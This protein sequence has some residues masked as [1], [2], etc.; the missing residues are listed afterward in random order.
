MKRPMLYWVILFML[1]EALYRILPIGIIIVIAAGMV[2]GI[3][4]IPAALV[5]KYKKVLFVGI[6]FFLFG[7][8]RLGDIR[9]QLSLCQMEEGVQVMVQGTVTG[10]N[11]S[12]ENQY[13]ILKAEK[14]NGEIIHIGIRL[15]LKTEDTIVL[16]SR[17]KGTG[18]TKAFGNATNPGEYDEQSYQYG[19]GVFLFLQDVEIIEK[20]EPVVPLRESLYQ[21]RQNVSKVYITLFGE[22]NGSLAAAM[23]LGNKESLDRD[24]KQ[25]YQR[26]GIA[27]LIAI[28][29][30]H[31]AM[32][33]G[34]LYHFLRKLLGSYP[35]SAGIGIFF[36]ILYGVMTGLSGA[37][38]RAVIMLITSIGAEVSG[39]RY[40]SITAVSLALF[41]M[42]VINP[43]QITQVGFLLS[44]GAILGIVL[45]YPVWKQLFPKMPQCLDG[46][47][48]SISVQLMI[49][50]VMLFYFYEV[51]VYGILLNV[52]VVPLMGILL[53]LLLLCGI[54]GSLYLKAGVL[55]AKPAQMIFVHYEQLCNVS[56][57]FPMHT[58]CT[59]RPSVLWLL[60]YYGILSLILAAGYQ[61]KYKLMSMS[62]ILY[63]G[64]FFLFFLPGNLKICMFDVGQGDGIYIRTPDGKHILMDGGSSSK[65]KVG[66]YVL[67]NG[68]KFYGGS[69]L[70]YVFISH[71]DSDHYSGILELFDEET[72]HIKHLVLPAVSNPDET[73]IQIEEKALE[74]GCDIHYMKRGDQLQVGKVTFYCLNP[75]KKAYEDKN[76]GSLVFLA[77]YGDFDILLTGDMDETVE[78]EI[79]DKITA[80]VEVL[81]VAHHGSASSSSE[82]FLRKLQPVTACVSV[83]EKNRY[84]HPADEVM[85]RLGQFCKKIYLTKDSGA[86][87]IDTNGKRYQITTFLTE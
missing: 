54:A 23:V 74:K 15:S 22:R 77:T 25:L 44:F 60:C 69:N 57:N 52:I 83:G 46:L 40:D 13:Y 1:G 79:A 3:R 66:T 35:V 87:T 5:K 65:Q 49:L 28:S 56:E 10:I 12:G 61:K 48:V 70:D 71:I 53:A 84:G 59:G 9:K 51:P 50:P 26:N 20:K 72:I 47:M 62:S 76:Q 14:V 33:G 63:I 29:G 42:L 32:I 67:K 30:L 8:V 73:Y 58:L 38:L 75:V 4:V 64:I 6:L 7:A 55:L 11:V 85:E 2:F 34:T 16:G 27:H 31:I 21:L 39:R 80:R 82:T 37:T 19:K 45:I 81:K 78:S 68:V 17:L 86:I 41:F 43:Y 24:V 36:I 18:E